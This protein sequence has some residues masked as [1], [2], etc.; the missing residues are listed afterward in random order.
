MA[1][2]REGKLTP[3]EQE[4]SGLP[5]GS[6]L[7][8]AIRGAD[9]SSLKKAEDMGG[10]YYYVDGRQGNALQI[11]KDHGV[12]Y[13]RLRVWVD[14]PDGYNNKEKVL[15]MASRIKALGMKLLI[16]F[17]YSDGWADPGKQYKPAAWEDYD[18]SQLKQAVYDHTFDVC[19]SLKAQGSIPDMVQVG[20][21]I[22]D[23]MLW[24]DGR[25]SL[26]MGNLA[27]LI[28]EGC[29]AVKACN[30]STLVMLH[31]AEGGDNTGARLLFDGLSARGSQWDVTGLSHYSYWHGPL[32]GL[33]SNLNDMAS[34]YGKPVIVVETCYPFT[35]DNADDEENIVN[36]S[37]S[38]MTFEYPISPAGQS[39][40]LRDIMTVVKNVPDGQ[41]WGVFYWEP[42]WTAVP[43]NGWDAANPQLGNNWENQALFDFSSRPLPAMNW[44]RP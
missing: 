7:G 32:L 28:R 43:G 2:D 21:E 44:F 18:F 36:A 39:D 4:A 23:G 13:I 31:R 20:N 6:G 19:S 30:S 27:E 9:V 29:R 5:A 41:G 10:R 11:L 14:P 26:N 33:Q 15:E 17:H 25:A 35:L 42:T 24:P 22:N 8:L 34:R 3:I 12:N 37:S 38:E 16:D 1:Q 40:N